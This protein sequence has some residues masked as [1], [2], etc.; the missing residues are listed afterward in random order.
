MMTWTRATA[1]VCQVCNCECKIVASTFF[2][3][4]IRKV[5]YCPYCGEFIGNTSK[6]NPVDY[7][8]EE[9]AEE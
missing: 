5:K 3:K 8:D 4:L 7:G 1:I 2:K 9:E 6:T